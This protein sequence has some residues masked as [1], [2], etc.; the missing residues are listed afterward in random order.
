VPALIAAVDRV[1]RPWSTKQG[2]YL[3][4]GCFCAATHNLMLI[5][6]D[7]AG[8][9]YVAMT[10]ASFAVLTPTAYALHA[11]FTFG[12]RCTGGG[13]L[14]Y[15]GGAAIGIPLSLVLMALLCSV[16]RLP[17]AVATPVTTVL[18]FL[19]N[20]ATAHLAVLG[21]LRRC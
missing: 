20:Y 5:G 13:L 19:W 7:L 6:G 3:L 16:L 11:R 15:A 1:I 21:R 2:R 8:V 18:L 12:E 14:R 4:I 9:G 17:V 10:L